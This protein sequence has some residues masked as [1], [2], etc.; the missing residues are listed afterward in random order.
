MRTPALLLALLTTAGPLLA[1]E[2]VTP[3]D[4]PIVV[5]RSDETYDD[6]KDAL[7]SAIEGQ[8]IKITNTLHIGDMLQRTAADTGLTDRIYGQAESLEFCSIPLSYKMS[9]ADPANM[10][11]CPLTISIYRKAGD[12]DNT[13]LA[14]R[15][16]RLLGDSAAAEQA[17]LQFLDTIVQETLE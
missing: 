1:A 4:A 17:L 8:G 15:R 9:Q 7:V 16:P 11:T 12:R 3:P 10:A 5:Y 13:Y 14:F 2:P 6:L